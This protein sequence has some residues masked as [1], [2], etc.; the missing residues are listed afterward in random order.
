LGKSLVWNSL[1]IQFW[2]LCAKNNEQNISIADVWD[3]RTLIL[4]FGFRR[5]FHQN[6]MNKW[7]DLSNIVE[8]LHLSDDDDS[9]IWKYESKGIY[10]ESSLYE[11]INF[12]VI[13][14]TY[15]PVVWKTHVLPRV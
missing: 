13:M 11:I 15:I 5:C 2:E 3:G 10:Y 12:N 4:S 7:S 6:L 9:L 1:A 8:S 14:P